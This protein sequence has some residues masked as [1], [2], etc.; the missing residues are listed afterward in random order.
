M[1]ATLS[2]KITRRFGALAS[3]L[4]FS[5]MVRKI[6]ILVVRTAYLLNVVEDLLFFLKKKLTVPVPPRVV[7]VHISFQ[8][9]S[10]RQFR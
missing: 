10:H 1:K 5:Y 2:V 7:S 9:D 4:R 3:P 8:R 6:K